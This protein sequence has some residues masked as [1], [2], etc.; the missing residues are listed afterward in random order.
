MPQL[1]NRLSSEK[2][3]I[4]TDLVSMYEEGVQKAK[5][6]FFN[7]LISAYRHTMY[8][9]V[10]KKIYLQSSL[11]LLRLLKQVS[12]SLQDLGCP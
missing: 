4:G 6:I 5:T 2:T 8:K 9:N 12:R 11:N 3:R 1:F 10:C 7:G